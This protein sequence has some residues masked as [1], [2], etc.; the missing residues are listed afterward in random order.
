MAFANPV[1][2]TNYEPNS[3]GPAGGPREDRERGFLSFPEPVAGTKARVRSSTFAD[4]YS[5][6]RQFYLSQTPI[7]QV[8]IGKA[9]VFELSK[10]EAPAIRARMVSHLLNIDAALAR[11][12]AN[13]LRLDPVPK[14]ADPAVQPIDLP[15]SPKLSIILNGP[16]SFRGRKLGVLITDGADARLIAALRDAAAM[17]GAMVEFVAPAVGGVEASDGTWIEA[18][19]KIDGGPS[20]LF[21]AVGLVVSASAIDALL[22]EPAARDFVSDAIAHC[23]FVAYVPDAVPLLGKAG[24]DQPDEGFL[25][26]GSVG[27]AAAF[28]A[29]CRSLRF[30]DRE[31]R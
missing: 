20:I 30:W 16:R 10:V 9:L 12:V 7:E 29:L 27:D 15:P 17:E 5:Q 26:L 31:P 18:H 25:E 21:D 22:L 2:R 28:L 14:P 24:L 13:G 19:H 23:K 1:G 3:R 4:H 8:H 11:T 6:A